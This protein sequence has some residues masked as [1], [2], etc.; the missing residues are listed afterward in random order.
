[1]AWDTMGLY[2]R[3]WNSAVKQW[4]G[5]FS[6]KWNY[7]ADPKEFHLTKNLQINNVLITIPKDR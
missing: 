1:M 4:A 2:G 3:Q 7:P 5:Q 6:R